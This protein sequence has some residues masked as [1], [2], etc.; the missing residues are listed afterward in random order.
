MYRGTPSRRSAYHGYSR[1]G[2]TGAIANEYGALGQQEHSYNENF[3]RRSP[4]PRYSAASFQMQNS[5]S[6]A[7]QNHREPAGTSHDHF[8][9]AASHTH[10]QNNNLFMSDTTYLERFSGQI[11]D[12]VPVISYINRLHE[13]GRLTTV[14][15]MKEVD[16]LPTELKSSFGNKQDDWYAHI[17]KLE[18]DAVGCVSKTHL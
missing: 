14:P 5:R 15:T 10:D 17:N 13:S 11:V 12:P 16:R 6:P 2:L 4:Y 7:W 1:N 18:L 9:R 3:S 8:G